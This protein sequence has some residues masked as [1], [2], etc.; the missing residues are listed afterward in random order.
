MLHQ[1]QFMALGK[2]LSKEN[3]NLIPK[4]RIC[5]NKMAK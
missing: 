1:A 3:S 5:K 4:K 2:N